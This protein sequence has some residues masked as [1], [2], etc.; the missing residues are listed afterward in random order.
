MMH[1]RVCLVRLLV[2][3]IYIIEQLSSPRVSLV[4]LVCR[5]VHSTMSHILLLCVVHGGRWKLTLNHKIRLIF[6]AVDQLVLVVIGG[7]VPCL[8]HT[9]LW[10]MLAQWRLGILLPVLPSEGPLGWHYLP[11]FGLLGQVDVLGRKFGVESPRQFAVPLQRVGPHSVFVEWVASISVCVQRTWSLV[12]L[13]EC[14]IVDVLVV[15]DV[16]DLNHT[17]GIGE[18]PL[19]PSIMNANCIYLPHRF[20]FLSNLD[21]LL[22]DLVV[23]CMVE[24]R[25][26]PV[27]CL[28]RLNDWSG[29]FDARR[30]ITWYSW[31]ATLMS[32]ACPYR[33]YYIRSEFVSLGYIFIGEYHIFL[34]FLKPLS[35]IL[36]AHAYRLIST[37]LIWWQKL[38]LALYLLIPLR[39]HGC[40]R[41]PLAYLLLELL[42]AHI[43][44]DLVLLRRLLHDL[45]QHLLLVL[46]QSNLRLGETGGLITRQWELPTG[47]PPVQSLVSVH[48]DLATLGDQSLLDITVASLDVD[49]WHG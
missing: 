30:G 28:A 44:T 16:G 39:P 29:L 36:F 25:D 6:I 42:L 21:M 11:L 41:E 46:A 35:A 40:D 12:G 23:V 13:I 38:T 18:P 5:S 26:P 15:H 14:E 49:L 24:G 33:V 1:H 2:H 7:E 4:Q 9:L 34:N 43:D 37:H 3:S 48:L 20:R 31:V 19:F 22:D 17:I 8:R 10:G 32:D 45:V 47:H 27:G